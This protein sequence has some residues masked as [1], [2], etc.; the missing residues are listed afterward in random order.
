MQGSEKVIAPP[1]IGQAAAIG[2][3]MATLS[4]RNQKRVIWDQSANRYSLA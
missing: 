2:G 1:T 3:H 4:F